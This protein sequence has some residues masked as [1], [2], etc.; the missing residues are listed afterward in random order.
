MS[1]LSFGGD[2]L[3]EAVVLSRFGKR[4]EL[5]TKL[6]HDEN[7][8]RVYE[9]I[10]K[11]KLSADSVKVEQGL[12]TAMNVVLVDDRGERHFLTNSNSNLRKLTVEDIDGYLNT[13]ADIVS[14]ASMFVSPMLGIP[15]MEYLFQ[16][17]KSRPNRTL[18][19]DMTKAKNGETLDDLKP[20]LPYVDYILPNEEEISLLTGNRDVYKNAEL[21]VEAGVK[22]AVIKRGEKGCLIR[23]KDK[24][25]EISAYHVR[26]AID[27]TGAGDCFAAGFLWALSEGLSLKD[28]GRFACVTAS[29]CV[30][31]MGAT[32]GLHSLKEPMY[33]MRKKW[34]WNRRQK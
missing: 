34:H 31:K 4:T 22:C 6:G 19:V 18:V 17:I 7:G 30:E 32:D 2:A 12:A 8:A 13:A 16:R 23:T 5:V 26:N 27:S 20:I 10:Q 1:K 33:R 11:N 15:E 9:Y 25:Y 21:L 29:C 28:C 3:N 14:F 24:Q